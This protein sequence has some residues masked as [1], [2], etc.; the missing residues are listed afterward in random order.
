[1]NTTPYPS[2]ASESASIDANVEILERLR[3]LEQAV[4]TL[5]DQLRYL[6]H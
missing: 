3:R 2:Y 5:R 6:R 1:M 4:E